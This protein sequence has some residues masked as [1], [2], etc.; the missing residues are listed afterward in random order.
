[1]PYKDREEA[2]VYRKEYQRGWYQRHK[3]T[4]LEK[5]L[6]KRR[7]RELNIRDWFRRYKSEL[8]CMECGENHPACLQFHHRD[9][10]E[11]NFTIS[12]AALRGTSIKTLIKEIKKCDILCVNCHAKRHWRETH[13]TDRWEEL[14]PPVE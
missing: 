10:E 12:N 14:L 6:D 1:M 11:K 2:A 3:D 7:K 8:Y 9:R 13:E 5:R 4:I